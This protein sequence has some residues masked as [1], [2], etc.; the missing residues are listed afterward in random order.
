MKYNSLIKLFQGALFAGVILMGFSSCKDYDFPVDDSY[1]RMFRPPMFSAEAIRATS[2]RLE[3][4]KVRGAE[5]YILELSRDSL[6]F[7]NPVSYELAADRDSITLL[8]LYSDTRYSARIK[9]LSGKGTPES[10]YHVL[11]FV[12]LGEQIFEEVI[13]GFSDAANANYLELNWIPG[14]NVTHLQLQAQGDDV[15]IIELT[16]GEKEVGYKKVDN[17]KPDTY[18]VVGIYRDENRRGRYVYTTFGAYPEG[19]QFIS[20]TDDLRDILMTSASSDLILVLEAGASYAIER[21]TIS[22]AIR[23]LVIMGNPAGVKPR[24]ETTSMTLHANNESLIV[25]NVE[26]HGKSNTADYLLN[27]NKTTNLHT[28]IIDN[29]YAHTFR[30]LIRMQNTANATQVQ[31]VQINNSIVANI[32]D[33]GVVNGATR[34]APFRMESVVISNSTING[35][36]GDVVGIYNP[37]S[38]YVIENCTFYNAIRHARYLFN[39]DNNAANIPNQLVVRNT[40]FGKFYYVGDYKEDESARSVNPYVDGTLSVLGSYALSDFIMN[41]AYAFG[42]IAPY[43]RSSAQ[44]FADPANGNFTIVDVAFPGRTTSGD[45]RWR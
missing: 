21:P 28:I 30:G 4:E 7:V 33:F 20:A 44:V 14:S 13:P 17:L 22:S 6:E 19:Y 40:I 42:A 18:Y 11:T 35:V 31:L 12:T 26:I 24:I 39:L 23:N 9:S 3:W 36:N 15:V 8:D 16:D 32:G 34:N 43:I 25:R 29:C 45:P 27:E 38:S 1:S 5:N 10:E 2:V 41:E 37:G